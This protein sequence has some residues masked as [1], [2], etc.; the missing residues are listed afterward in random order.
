[1]SPVKR[2]AAKGARGKAKRKPAAKTAARK[3]TRRAPVRRYEESWTERT[4]RVW[5]RRWRGLR[6]SA[7]VYAPYA[8][9]AVLAIGFLGIYSVWASGVADR[10]GQAVV[11]SAENGLK[12]LG[13]RVEEVTVTGRRMARR[14]ALAA[15]L[16][17][18]R[19]AL[20]FGID[21]EEARARLARVEW[22]RSVEIR[23]RLPDTLAIVINEETPFAIWQVEGDFALINREG[24]VITRTIPAQYASLP[25]VVGEG[26]A[27]HAASFFAL[28]D[29]EPAVREQ[30][31]AAI[32]VGDR[33]WNLRLRN[34]VEV[35][36]PD[37][38]VEA[39]L[40]ELADLEAEYGIFS[41]GISLIDMR[42]PDKMY[43]RP[44]AG[45][46]QSEGQPP[47]A[48]PNSPNGGTAIRVHER[49]T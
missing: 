47:P 12:G 3:T 36:L 49:E 13:F 23:R 40:I 1:M 32:R 29:R 6:R 15:A 24:A 9:F 7:K 37:T 45:A 10:A 4:R 27:Q 46:D 44:S 42:V 35:R 41:R 14:D 20:I 39:A 19:G 22:V 21:L 48:S 30:L 26:A 33:R 43:L 31:A 17:V 8:Y 5:S 16:G 25:H 11:A 28:L 38:G 18:E 2:K 34:G